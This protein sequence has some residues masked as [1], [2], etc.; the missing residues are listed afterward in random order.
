MLCCG[1]PS[2]FFF[3]R[4]KFSKKLIMRIHEKNTDLYVF[5]RKLI[6]KTPGAMLRF[7]LLCFCRQNKLSE[8]RISLKFVLIKRWQ[9]VLFMTIWFLTNVAGMSLEKLSWI[10]KFEFR[11]LKS[12]VVCP[13]CLC[14]FCLFWKNDTG[15][16][17][18]DSWFQIS[19]F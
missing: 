3:G 6:I 4:K 18:R 17:G 13:V 15:K 11:N 9:Y 14:Q 12:A 7:A 5:L 8:N 2:G 10:L 19:N 1:S 16:Q